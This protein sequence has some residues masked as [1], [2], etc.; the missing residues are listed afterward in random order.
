[1]AAIL[2]PDNAIA[3]AQIRLRGGWKN[4]GVTGFA[5][6]ILVGGGIYSSAKLLAS[7]PAVA[8]GGWLTGLLGLQSAILLLFGASRIGAAIRQDHATRMIESHR[9]MP[10]GAAQAIFGYLAGAASQALV[11][12]AVNVAVGAIVA[13]AAG[14]PVPL[15]LAANF[16]LAAF[17][18]FIWVLSAFWAFLVKTPFALFLLLGLG[19]W[20]SQGLAIQLVPAL[21]TLIGPLMGRTVFSLR[22]SAAEPGLA[23]VV[24]FGS[25]V[26]IGT[27]CFLGAARRFRRGD[28]PAF[29][30]PMSL[31]LLAGWVVISCITILRWD[32]FKPEFLSGRMVDTDSQL[33]GS[34]LSSMLLALTPIA[35]SARAQ[36][37]WRARV[38]ND[39]RRSR[40]P[41]STPLLAVIATLII[42]CLVSVEWPGAGFK[43]GDLADPILRTALVVLLFLLAAGY[44]LQVLIRCGIRP[45]A[46]ML[47]WL[48][49]S[50]LGPLLGDV[51]RYNMFADQHGSI[52]QTISTCGPLGALIQIWLPLTDPSVRPVAS[53]LGIGFQALVVIAFYLLKVRVSKPRKR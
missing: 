11:L 7:S 41:F 38:P 33:I 9:M 5:Y 15:W 20:F 31:L 2:S 14:I 28:A 36:C 30:L 18:A 35:G 53:T 3:W 50:W 25:Q 46:P 21:T 37:E 26:F 40:R 51:V 8:Y 32:D 43:T 45:L 24:S 47:I 19:A 42:L 23:Y 44:L 16:V 13:M 48:A 12:A 27:I 39:P 4:L 34:L 10:I 49:I 52:L 6:A 29:T 22:T 1:M 17:C